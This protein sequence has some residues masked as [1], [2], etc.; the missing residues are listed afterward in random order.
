MYDKAHTFN[1]YNK[2]P[3]AKRIPHFFECRI[4][5]I[6]TLGKNTAHNI[7]EILREIERCPKS[8]Q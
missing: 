1:D 5:K 6:Q 7:Q 8:D 2:P 3:I 4:M